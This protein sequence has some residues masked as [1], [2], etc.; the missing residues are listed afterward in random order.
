MATC[1]DSTGFHSGRPASLVGGL[2]RPSINQW[3]FSTQ[4]VLF[5]VHGAGVVDHEKHVDIDD[6]AAAHDG[7]KERDT[8]GSS[9]PISRSK[10]PKLHATQAQTSSC[11]ENSAWKYGNRFIAIT[12][13]LSR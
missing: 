5:L 2:V 3:D 4:A 12:S 13:V 7:S 1:S 11:F 6:A 9:G 10:Q 8:L